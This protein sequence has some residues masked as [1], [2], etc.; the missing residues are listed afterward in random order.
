MTPVPVGPFEFYNPDRLWAI[1]LV[2]LLIALYIVALRFSKRQGI[3]YTNTGV[4]AA[5]LPRQSQWKRHATVGMALCSMIL[6]AGAWARPVGVERVPRERATVVLVLDSSLS[7]QA[8]D[9]SPTRFEAGKAAAKVFVNALP[10]QY[11]LA[12]VSLSGSPAVLSPPTTD[13]ALALRAIDLME[14]Q[15]G[16]AIGDALQS[17][18]TAIAMAPKGEDEEPAPALV[19]LLSDGGNTTGRDPLTAAGA[20]AAAKVPVYTIAYG[21][22]NGHVDVDGTRENVAPDEV[23]LKEISELTGARATDADNAEELR[24]VYRSLRSEVGTEEIRKDVSARWAMYA[25]AFAVVA[26]LGAVSMAARWP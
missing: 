24:D 5:V 10:A 26:S 21:T 2:P 16:T 15:E 1:L 23:L 6:I 8:T 14:L 11:N 18:Q 12:I 4:L 13:R 19:V 17:A 22:A 9:V 7:M 20:L 3:R 25:L